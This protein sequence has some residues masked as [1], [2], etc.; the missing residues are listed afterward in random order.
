M[1]HRIMGPGA[2]LFCLVLS[3]FISFAIANTLIGCNTVH[4]PVAPG[5]GDTNCHVSNQTLHAI[6]I[7]NYSVPILPSNPT[8]SWTFGSRLDPGPPPSE[9]VT[10]ER[11]FYLGTPPTLDL[12]DETSFDGCAIYFTGPNNVNLF[13][14]ASITP[15]GQSHCS[16]LLSASCSAALSVTL[17]TLAKGSNETCAGLAN[18]LSTQIPT[19]CLGVYSSGIFGVSHRLVT[20]RQQYI[21][22][23]SHLPPKQRLDTSL[24][25]QHLYSRSC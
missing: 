22:L 10:I 13:Y 25:L 1:M 2:S 12:K 14:N 9:N 16:N 6:G 17:S 11:V 15:D 7:T 20:Y 23:Q 8:I 3:S 21:E 4:C 24:L 19:Q 5:S 18:K